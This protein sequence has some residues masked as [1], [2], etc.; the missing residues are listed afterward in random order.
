MFG[1]EREARG[2]PRVMARPCSQGSGKSWAGLEPVAEVR[3]RDRQCDG[4]GVL[5]TG[6][7]KTA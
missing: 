4:L 6:L 3:N 5:A 2:G 7:R 1:A